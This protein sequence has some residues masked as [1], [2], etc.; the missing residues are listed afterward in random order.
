MEPTGCPA[1]SVPNYQSTLRNIPEE[2]DLIYTA[3]Q[4]WNHAVEY[5]L[6]Q[7]SPYLSDW[8]FPHKI[9]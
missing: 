5:V 9:L 6:N 3:A 7:F 4:A 1:T 2:Q 8:S